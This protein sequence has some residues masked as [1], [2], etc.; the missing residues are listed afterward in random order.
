MT[1]DLFVLD[2]V[3]PV[4]TEPTGLAIY[5]F[6]FRS[7]FPCRHPFG[8]DAVENVVARV[9]AFDDYEARFE[10]LRSEGIT[11]LHSPAEHVRASTL[12]GWYPLLEGLTPKSVWFDEAPSASAVEAALGWPVFIKGERQTNRHRRSTS[13][14]HSAAEFEAVMR[15][16][17]HDPVL[18]WQKVV[19]REYVALKPV[20]D[21]D[22]ERIPSSFE[23]RFFCWR[24]EPVSAGRYWW[25]GVD[26]TLTERERLGAQKVAREAAARV[27][28]PFL[29]VDVAQAIDG[30]WLV[31]E[32]NDGQESGYA[33]ASPFGLWQRIVDAERTHLATS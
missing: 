30:R 1:A 18:N 31:I 22:P 16:W 25:Q 29:V 8:F 19:C 5:D 12:P 13:I 28:V 11:L 26:Y 14:A 3:L 21:P 9:G 20:E 27:A 17:A 33:G 15:A 32:C 24:G 4:L 7:F 23:F 6:D 2:G 10:A